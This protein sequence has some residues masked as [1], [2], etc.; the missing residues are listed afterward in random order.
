MKTPLAI[1]AVIL[2]LSLAGNVYQWKISQGL[3]K[4]SKAYLSEVQDKINEQLAWQAQAQ[5]RI[6]SIH[7]KRVR[8]SLSFKSRENGLKIEI[9]RYESKIASL[10]PQVQA[11]IDSFPDLRQF[12]ELQDSIIVK[13]DSLIR[14]QDLFCAAQISDFNEI[15]ALHQQKFTAQ[16]Q[17][18]EA[19]MET[20]AEARKD[21]VKEK[22]KK[23]FF[24]IT[25]GILTAG[26]LFLAVRE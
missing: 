22:R 9:K 16:Q 24:K 12:L 7:Y 4:E 18:S 20:A 13:Q 3:Q 25:S 23:N 19:W 15:L 21:A 17:I 11:K 14:A 10:R 8:D 6:D 2:L 1:L 5:T 26:I